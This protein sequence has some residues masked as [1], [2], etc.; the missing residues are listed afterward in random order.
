MSGRPTAA[1]ERRVHVDTSAV[2]HDGEVP[3]D[4]SEPI[5]GD[6]LC[7]GSAEKLGSASPV[8]LVDAVDDQRLGLGEALRQRLGEKQVLCGAGAATLVQHPRH[9]AVT[10]TAIG[11]RPHSFDQV[12]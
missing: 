10:R 8:Q 1:R 12:E 5:L 11:Q 6:R 4:I 7:N 2:Y 3:M 9:G